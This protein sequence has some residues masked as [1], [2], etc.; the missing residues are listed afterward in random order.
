VRAAQIELGDA[1]ALL[2]QNSGT[3][4]LPAGFYTLFGGLLERDTL[5]ALGS[6]DVIINGQI[7][8]DSSLVTG[9]DVLG[10]LVDNDSRPYFTADSAINGCLVSAASCATAVTPG[11]ILQSDILAPVTQQITAEDVV[12]T[13]D[14]P[15]TDEERRQRELAEAEAKRVPIPPPAPIIDTQPLDPVIDVDEPVAGSGNP[16]LLGGGTADMA[17]GRGK[18]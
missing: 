10:L 7:L 16:A 1:D 2:V 3:R 4:A 12:P 5:P 6:V 18:Q 8:T 13:D 11:A 9:T 15:E 14:Q 17:I